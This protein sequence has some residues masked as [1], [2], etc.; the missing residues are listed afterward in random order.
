ME[1]CVS[2]ISFDV[3]ASSNIVFVPACCLH[4]LIHISD[5]TSA[6]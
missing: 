5:H 4:I 6:T 1:V 3:M 2:E